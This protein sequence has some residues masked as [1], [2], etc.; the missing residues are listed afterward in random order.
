MVRPTTRGMFRGRTREC[1]DFL[2]GCHATRTLAQG[3]AVTGTHELFNVAHVVAP[4]PPQLDER[5]IGSDHPRLRHL[6]QVSN[7]VHYE[8]AF[9]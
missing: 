1:Q 3:L 5:E 4:E 9:R 7:L 8:Q 2:L 6:Q